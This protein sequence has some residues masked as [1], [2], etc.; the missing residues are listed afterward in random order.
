MNNAATEAQPHPSYPQNGNRASKRKNKSLYAM[1]SLLG[2]LQII[3][4]IFILFGG[5]DDFGMDIFSTVSLTL[6][7]DVYIVLSLMS[8]LPILRYAAWAMTSIGYVLSLITTWIPYP[9]VNYAS[10]VSSHNEMANSLHEHM[11]RVAAGGWLIASFWVAVAVFAVFYNK[12]M[13][14]DSK[15]MAGF[16]WTLVSIGMISPIPQALALAFGARESSVAS[17]PV[18]LVFAGGILC[19]AFACILV[20]AIIADAFSRK[21][22]EQAPPRAGWAGSPGQQWSQFPGAPEHASTR[23][24]FFPPHDG[25]AAPHN[26]S[27]GHPGDSQGYSEGQ[28]WGNA[29]GY[30][31]QSA[32]GYPAQGGQGYPS[33][34]AQTSAYRQDAPWGWNGAGDQGPH[35][36]TFNPNWG[37]PQERAMNWDKNENNETSHPSDPSQPDAS[38]EDVA[39]RGKGSAS[40]SPGDYPQKPLFMPFDGVIPEEARPQDEQEGDA[41]ASDAT[42]EPVDGVS[43]GLDDEHDSTPTAPLPEVSEGE[44]S[45]A[46]QDASS[47]TFEEAV[48]SDDGFPEN[49]SPSRE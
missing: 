37:S 34:P 28:G 35:K 10:V 44:D 19:F 5:R 25:A 32:Q 16:F 36:S 15:L 18:R 41:V 33:Q 20:V 14:L 7:A 30:P 42:G 39:Y 29:Q 45:S 43:G 49:G 4:A 17:I 27:Q 24:S 22:D 11:A 13:A 6:A 23:Q 9:Q 3:G 8:R 12:I 38:S 40:Q 26:P 21:A 1:Y 46:A 31:S 48:A 47:V 2:A